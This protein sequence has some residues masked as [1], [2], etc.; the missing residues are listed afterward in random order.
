M[1]GFKKKIKNQL[2]F[3]KSKVQNSPCYHFHKYKDFKT[4][5]DIFAFMKKYIAVIGL[6]LLCNYLSK[7]QDS[8]SFN[9]HYLPMHK[10]EQTA[11]QQ[12][13]STTTFSGN[14]SLLTVL[15]AK[16]V[17]NP[18]IVNK[19]MTVKAVTITGAYNDNDKMPIELKYQD[20]TDK[21]GNILIPK[22]AGFF[23]TVQKNAMPNFD[24]IVLPDKNDITTKE[25]SFKPS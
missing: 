18:M 16:G 12:L 13:I 6:L 5:P 21:D 15:K 20:T 24:S 11:I 25:R 3:K 1:D 10:Y 14:D 23:G 8:I 4:T 2:L 22:G 19:S 7:A 9:M 17:S